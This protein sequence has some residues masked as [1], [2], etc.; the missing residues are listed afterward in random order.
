MTRLKLA[1]VL[2]SFAKFQPCEA[3]SFDS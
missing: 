3:D 1:M 2:P